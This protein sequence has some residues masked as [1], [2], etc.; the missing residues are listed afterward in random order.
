MDLSRHS[1]LYNG[2]ERRCLPGATTT[3]HCL[4]TRHSARPGPETPFS[5]CAWARSG[6]ESSPAG[7]DPGGGGA[8]EGAGAQSWSLH[9][10]QHPP[11]ARPCCFLQPWPTFPPAP[12]RGCLWCRPRAQQPPPL[13]CRPLP[14]P[15]A[16]GATTHH[17]VTS[18]TKC[19][20]FFS[21]LQVAQVLLARP[22]H[23][24]HLTGCRGLQA[25]GSPSTNPPSRGDQRG[26]VLGLGR[27]TPTLGRAPTS[28]W[29][30]PCPLHCPGSG[31][32]PSLLKERGIPAGCPSQC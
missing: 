23:V 4:S 19:S 28:L 30:P 21:P 18:W 14:R 10:C 5:A 25:P 29:G 13:R 1:H 16:R 22:E 24:P 8:A 3:F 20:S 17:T 6:V 26:P 7:S 9:S 12:P 11:R 2:N 31:A 15:W 32:H 27:V